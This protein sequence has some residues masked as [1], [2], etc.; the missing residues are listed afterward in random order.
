M[1]HSSTDQKSKSGKQKIFSKEKFEVRVEN[2]KAYQQKY[3]REYRQQQKLKYLV[4]KTHQ[5]EQPPLR[6]SNRITAKGSKHVTSTEFKTNRRSS[7]KLNFPKELDNA[8]QLILKNSQ[9]EFCSNSY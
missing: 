2:L 1:N 6:R 3:Q 8:L 9:V 7:N 5:K 4:D